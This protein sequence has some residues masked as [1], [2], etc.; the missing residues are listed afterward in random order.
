[1]PL[2]ASIAFLC[3]YVCLSVCLSLYMYLSVC[4]SLY[5]SICGVVPAAQGSRARYRAYQVICWDYKSVPFAINFSWGKRIFMV[6]NY[7]FLYVTT[8]PMSKSGS[9]VLLISSALV[10][11]PIHHKEAFFY[12][13]KLCFSPA[14][15][16]I[17]FTQSHIRIKRL[18]C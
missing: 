14:M 18:T 6:Q 3:L 1:M 4:L 8:T 7:A 15:H 12:R 5:L 16:Y 10:H 17:F 11:V 13:V 2:C 9:D